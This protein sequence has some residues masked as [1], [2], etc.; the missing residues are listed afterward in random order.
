MESYFGITFWKHDLLSKDVIPIQNMI[1]KHD[2]AR[3]MIPTEN[4]KTTD[5]AKFINSVNSYIQKVKHIVFMMEHGSREKYA[6]CRRFPF[7][8]H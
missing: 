3:N 4:N 8:P 6:S 7:P 5:A 1:S 2:L